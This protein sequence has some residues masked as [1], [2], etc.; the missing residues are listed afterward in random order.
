MLQL[1]GIDKAYRQPDGEVRVLDGIDFTL[2]AGHC[3][4]LLGESGSGKSTLLHLVAGLEYPDGGEIIVDGAPTSRF[5]E[6][7]WNRLRRQTLGLVFQQYH[8]VPTLDVQDNIL[9]QA[10]L[11]GR[12][13][14]GRHDRL[15]ERLG[16]QPLLSRLP[17]QLSG[18]QQQ[19]VAIA[20]AL[21]H[22]PG[23]VLADEPTGNLDEGTSHRVMQLFAELVRE[24]A[25]SLLLVTHSGEMAAYLDSRWLLHDGKIGP[26][27]S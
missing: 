13:E 3:A 24:A 5:T 21:M 10:R 15:V 18:G 20:R 12:V 26:Y 11:A 7:R 14:S 27:E 1:I 25:G 6:S 17:H 16:L 9:L 23:L 19:R 22:Q 2:P 4:A 8:L